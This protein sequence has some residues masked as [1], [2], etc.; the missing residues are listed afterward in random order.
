MEYWL[1]SSTLPIEELVIRIGLYYYSTDI[2]K[3]NVYL[4]STL[5][6]RL[7]TNNDFNLV[8]ERLSA[9][10]TRPTLSGF[11][12]FS[13]EEDKDAIKGKVQI[14]TMHKSKG[15]EFDHVFIPELSEKALSVDIEQ[16][17]L[18]DSTYFMEEVRSFNSKY[19]KKSEQEL[20]E[21]S[22]EENLRLFYVAVTRA[23]E[24]LIIVQPQTRMYYPYLLM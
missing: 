7:N 4:I 20:K 3:S 19:K 10:S 6:R 24:K 11:K 14:M 12:F 21:F 5:V 23:K 8:L 9:L 17:Q 16:L 18:K 13:E 22:A 1:N 2:E 15:D